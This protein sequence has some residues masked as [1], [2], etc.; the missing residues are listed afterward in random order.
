MILGT[1]FLSKT[2]VKLDYNRGEM[3][4]Y[5]NMLPMPPCRGLMSED[6]DHIEDSYFIQHE[7]ELLGQD[8]L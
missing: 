7:D 5:D 2:G 6:F 1:N 3:L 8:W 4:W